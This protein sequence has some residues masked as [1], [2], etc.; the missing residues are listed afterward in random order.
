MNR[1]IHVLVI[2]GVELLVIIIELKRPVVC[3]CPS[4]D[5]REVGAPCL[6]EDLAGLDLSTCLFFSHI[7]P[8]NLL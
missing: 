4:A 2:T 5:W 7:I 6:I 8:A 3:R 1:K